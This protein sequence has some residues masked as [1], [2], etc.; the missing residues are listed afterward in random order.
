[1]ETKVDGTIYVARCGGFQKAD[2]GCVAILELWLPGK[3]DIQLT[4]TIEKDDAGGFG[5]VPDRDGAHAMEIDFSD[6]AETDD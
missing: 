3:G 1:M 4:G 6:E 5:F 2:E